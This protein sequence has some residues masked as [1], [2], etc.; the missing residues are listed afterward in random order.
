MSC[1]LLIVELNKYIDELD[2]YIKYLILIK[3]IK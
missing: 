1:F 3:I 2:L